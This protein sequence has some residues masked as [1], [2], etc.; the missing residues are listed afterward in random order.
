LEELLKE[1]PSPKDRAVLQNYLLY[2]VTG[3][4]EA[5][6]FEKQVLLHFGEVMASPKYSS[7]RSVEIGASFRIQNYDVGFRYDL[8]RDALGAKER[9]VCETK[10][11]QWSTSQMKN[12]YPLGWEDPY[13]MCNAMLALATTD[14]RVVEAA[15]E[16]P[17]GPKAYFDRM[18]DGCFSPDGCNPDQKM[19]GA[20]WLWCRG[21]ERLGMNEMGFGYTGKGGGTMR[22]LLEGYFLAA[23][24][25]IDIPG[26]APFV[27]RSAITLGQRLRQADFFDL[28]GALSTGSLA[29]ASGGIRGR[30][31]FTLPKLSHPRDVFRA[32]LVLGRLPDGAGDWPPLLP[33]RNE[34]FY[35]YDKK[36]RDLVGLPQIEYNPGVDPM[37]L[38]IQL[39]LVFELAHQRWPDAGFD[40]FLC[41]MRP[42]QDGVYRPSLFWGLD[43]IAASDTRPPAVKSTVF[44]GLGM[45]LLRA[46]EG[47]AFWQS[48]APAAVLRLTDAAGE[49][50]AGSALSL[51]SLHAF[52][53]PIYRYVKPPR[54]VPPLGRSGKSH[55][56]VVV[57]NA[58]RP[59]VGKGSLRQRF[60]S[61]VKFVSVRSEPPPQVKRPA[62]KQPI[63]GLAVL[64]APPPPNTLPIAAGVEMERCLALTREYLFDV[65]RLASGE[66]HTYDWIVHALGSAQPERQEDWK[67]SESLDATL[68]AVQEQFVGQFA[69]RFAYPMKYNFG[70]Q[71]QLDAPAAGWSLSAV[72]TCTG[73]DPA[74]T[75]LGP[76]WYDRKVGVRITMLGEPGTQTFFA[77][78][79][80]PRRLTA[81][82]ESQLRDIRFPRRLRG[83]DGRYDQGDYERTEI[84]I[85]PPAGAKKEEPEE[86]KPGIQQFKPVGEV[87]EKLPETG[88]VA[89]IAQRRAANTLFVALHEPFEKLEWKIDQ[90]RRIQQTA[91]AVAVAVRGRQPSAVDD[92]VM[93]RMGRQAEEPVTLGD[94]AE[95]FTF[96]SFA[97][98]RIGADEVLVSGG[99]EAMKIKIRGTPK[100]LV[101]GQEKKGTVRD[102]WLTLGR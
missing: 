90:F 32:P 21:V 81:Q 51:H 34:L 54:G 99:I 19:V 63:N 52:N 64:E 8:F 42:S 79:V 6:Q 74:Q 22:R 30:V 11:N 75:I 2:L 20:M 71:R 87:A 18:V 33:F 89:I 77:R 3:D 45:T 97:Y 69:D 40:Y 76:E 44:P 98:V 37:S 29:A 50:T 92:R 27:G 36:P 67:P 17:G 62:P 70:Q 94:G 65:Y 14:K 35:S 15:F 60:D 84:P 86:A 93:V 41:R 39:P 26:G 73:A 72:Q 16:A 24:P 46:E 91:D 80:L 38:G 7:G 43:P 47:R 85:L 78:E 10:F 57:D 12:D 53:R 61:A 58:D 102:G 101:N 56:T 4:K 83:R 59:G 100:L 49:E 96:K 28:P 9:S 25:Q 66:E 13:A 1:A 95:E 88:G 23:D 82:E 48:P 68:A 5:E 55:N 31:L